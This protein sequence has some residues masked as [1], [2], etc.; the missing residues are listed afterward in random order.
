[1][2]ARVRKVEPEQV[3]KANLAEDRHEGDE[4]D[5]ARQVQDTPPKRR[6]FHRDRCL[7]Q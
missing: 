4:P 2:S 3:E 1:V 5:V 7:S 6:R